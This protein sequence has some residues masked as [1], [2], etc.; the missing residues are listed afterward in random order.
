MVAGLEVEVLP[1]GP[2]GG[3]QTSKRQGRWPGA[4][5][6]KAFGWMPTGGSGGT[7]PQKR[8]WKTPT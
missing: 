3:N 6:R 8:L 4:P 2:G 7:Q 5:G 1:L